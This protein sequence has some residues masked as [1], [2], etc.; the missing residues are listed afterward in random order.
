MLIA[1]GASTSVARSCGDEDYDN[2]KTII[3]NAIVLM[4]IIVSTISTGI[5]IFQDTIIKGLGASKIYF[6]LQKIM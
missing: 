2:L 6:L 5:F 3:P 1:I 4:L